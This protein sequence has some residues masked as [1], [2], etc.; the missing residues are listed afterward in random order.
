LDG[1]GVGDAGFT[2]DASGVTISGLTI[3]DFNGGGIDNAGALTVADCTIGNNSA[4]EGGG[5]ENDGFEMTVTHC[6]ITNNSAIGQGGGIDDL[7]RLTVTA[8][9][10]SGKVGGDIKSGKSLRE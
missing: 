8:C 3:Q 4:G 10:I 9:T 7:G 1:G 6:T 2:V 5:I